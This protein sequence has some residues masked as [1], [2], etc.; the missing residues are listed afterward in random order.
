MR[1]S[2]LSLIVSLA[3]LC[4]LA[5]TAQAAFVTMTLSSVTPQEDVSLTRNG[6]TSWTTMPV[7]RFN[8]TGVP[9]NPV[10]LQGAFSG[11]CIELG[12]EVDVGVT[13]TNTFEP[14]LLAS[15]PL[16]AAAP[17]Q[18][19]GADS[20]Q[21]IGNLWDNHLPLLSTTDDFAAF[22][23]CVWEIVYD[24]GLDLGAGDFQMRNNATL[25]GLAQGWL[26]ALNPM[27][28]V[29]TPLSA[30]SSPSWQ[31]MLIPSP[32]ALPLLTSGLFT[33]TMRRRR[34]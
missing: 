33:L 15:S 30:L 10:G 6:G 4:A 27:A 20:A 7:G 22:Q 14:I 3:G 23:M 17:D 1:G 34:K 21:L 18:P 16:P 24:V 19:M 2:R 29:K 11:F 13:Y 31:D 28:T 25:Q 9:S 5:G 8:W 26:N 32:G 12:Q